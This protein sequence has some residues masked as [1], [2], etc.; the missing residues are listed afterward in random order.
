MEK[1]WIKPKQTKI[2]LQDS[3]K[4][5]FWNFESWTIQ[6]L[7]CSNILNL[8]ISKILK[9]SKCPDKATLK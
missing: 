7:E 8:G 4:R 3:K 2:S 9:F 5:K 6:K 1:F